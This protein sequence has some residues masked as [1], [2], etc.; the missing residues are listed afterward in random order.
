MF[1]L[2]LEELGLLD[3]VVVLRA[4]GAFLFPAGNVELVFA[5][6]IGPD[7]EVAVHAALAAH[8][9]LLRHV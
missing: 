1:T 4:I 3:E 6:I 2:I 9:Q 8:L 5:L 7:L